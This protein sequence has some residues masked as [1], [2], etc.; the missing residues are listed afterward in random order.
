MIV[1]LHSNSEV[2]SEPD[3]NPERRTTL[4]ARDLKTKWQLSPEPAPDLAGFW[5]GRSLLRAYNTL[6][7]KPKLAASPSAW[8]WSSLGPELS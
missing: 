3:I 7:A 1:F 8:A 4:Q 2:S 6:L 5:F